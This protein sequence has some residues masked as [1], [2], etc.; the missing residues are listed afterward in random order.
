MCTKVPEQENIRKFGVPDPVP[1]SN[2]RQTPAPKGPGR[3]RVRTPC[4][5][6]AGTRTGL[7]TS[8]VRVRVGRGR[9]SLQGQY[10]E[11]PTDPSDGRNIARFFSHHSPSLFLIRFFPENRSMRLGFLTASKSRSMGEKNAI[12]RNFKNRIF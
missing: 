7:G 9:G 6:G 5:H 8:G 2:F 10:C 4:R 12:Y 3:V 1:V 11:H